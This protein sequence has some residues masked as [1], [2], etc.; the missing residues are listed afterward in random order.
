MS[1]RLQP[2]PYEQVRVQETPQETTRTQQTVAARFDDRVVVLRVD[3]DHGT[4][5]ITAADGARMEVMV[6]DR[7][8]IYP[9]EGASSVTGSCEPASAESIELLRADTLSVDCKVE[10]GGV[11]RIIMVV[12]GDG[13]I[14]VLSPWNGPEEVDGV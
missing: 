3:I 8:G 7:L 1:W 4:T 5:E 13:T 10:V 9:E 12:I 6:V 2:G 11:G 14:D